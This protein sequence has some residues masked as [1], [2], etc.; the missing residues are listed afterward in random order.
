MDSAR[1]APCERVTTTGSSPGPSR[2]AMASARVRWPRP[3]PFEVKK[4]TRRGVRL[5]LAAGRCRGADQGPQALGVAARRE[6][7]AHELHRAAA[8][9]GAGPGIGVE[10]ADE[11]GRPGRCRVDGRIL[12][13]VDEGRRQ[14]GHAPGGQRL[15]HGAAEGLDEAAVM[16]VDEEVQGA[17]EVPWRHGVEGDDPPVGGQA[18][19]KLHEARRQAQ[20]ADAHVRGGRVDLEDLRRGL[21]PFEE[22]GPAVAADDRQRAHRARPRAAPRRRGRGCCASPAP[23]SGG[24]SGSATSCSR[25]RGPPVPRPAAGR[26]GPPR[27]DAPRPSHRKGRRRRRRAGGGRSP[28]AAP[29]RG[30]GGPGA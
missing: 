19:Q 6:A 8:E 23:C 15:E 1:C 27:C 17:E 20:D 3:T 12:E 25:T 2:R 30:G 21:G 16:V 11:R 18:A 7:V 26:A 4:R 28:D 9:P 22:I 29:P 24:G 14:H 13:E 10:L 5:G